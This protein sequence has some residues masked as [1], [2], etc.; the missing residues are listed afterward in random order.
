[1]NDKAKGK[2]DELSDEALKGVAGGG[3]PVVDHTDSVQGQTDGQPV[4][5]DGPGNA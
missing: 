4:V 1:M 5:G 2:D 3:R